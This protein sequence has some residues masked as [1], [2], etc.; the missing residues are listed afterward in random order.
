MNRLSVGRAKS[1]WEANSHTANQ[2]I[3][4]LLENSDFHQVHK[5]PPLIPILSQM[6]PV[7]PLPPYFRLPPRLRPRL[8]SG[9]LLPF[10]FSNQNVVYISHLSDACYMA[11]IRSP[12][13]VTMRVVTVLRDVASVAQLAIRHSRIMQWRFLSVHLK[14]FYKTGVEMLHAVYRRD[15]DHHCMWWIRPSP[16]GAGRIEIGL[17]NVGRRGSLHRRRCKVRPLTR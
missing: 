5:S 15:W 13:H 16:V 11:L 9:L 14:L 8:P 2:E 12:I 3:T 17:Q 1:P 10:R 4:R 7:Y 6:N